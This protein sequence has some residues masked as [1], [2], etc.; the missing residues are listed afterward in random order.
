[1]PSSV[2][3]QRL[4]T[5]STVPPAREAFA[6]R[7]IV[8]AILFALFAFAGI[9][10]AV[11][12][13]RPFPLSAAPQRDLPGF[14]T[15]VTAPPSEVREGDALLGVTPLVRVPLPPGV[16][17]LTIDNASIGVHQL[18]PIEV[19]SGEVLQHDFSLR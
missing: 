13:V 15:I 7:R 12:T 2:R 10:I 8:L 5:G 9:L 17:L 6:A 4:Y 1:M 3:N 16:H 11:R 19:R 14:V 18:L